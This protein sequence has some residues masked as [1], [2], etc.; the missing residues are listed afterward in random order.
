MVCIVAESVVPS[1]CSIYILYFL[2][3]LKLK[4]CTVSLNI[5]HFRFA[6][7][8]LKLIVFCVPKVQ[9]GHKSMRN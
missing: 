8:S 4:S 5:G 3:T 6:V 1:V 7:S 2:S 9:S